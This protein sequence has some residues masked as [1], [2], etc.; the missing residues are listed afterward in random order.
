VL[1][2]YQPG[3]PLYQQNIFSDAPEL[4]YL[5][6]DVLADSSARQ[7][8]GDQNPLL[9]DRTAAVVN[10]LTA[11]RVENWTVGYT[12][13]MVIGVHLGRAD[14]EPLALAD[15][16]LP[17]AA[18][19]W[20][21][22]MQYAN[23]RDGVPP[24]EWQRPENVIELE[25]CQRSGL[26]PNGIC[27][28]KRDLFLDGIE[29]NQPDTFWQAFRINTQTGLLATANTPDALQTDQVFFVPPED[30]LDWWTANRLRLP[31]T[32]Y[33]AIYSS[34]DDVFGVTA[35]T[36][37][38]TYAYIQGEVEIRGN[39]NTDNL[40]YY[41]LAYGKD[42][43]PTQWTNIV[44]QQ[45]V[46]T[47]GEP[48][49]MWDTAG[50]DGL[51]TLEL[52]AVLQNGVRE[53]DTIQVRIDNTPPTIILNTDQPGKIY[54][55][56][57]EQVITVVATVQDN[58]TIARVEFYHNGLRVFTDDEFPFQYDYGITGTGIEFFRADVFDAAGNQSTSEEI[59]VEVRR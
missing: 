49:V 24:S 44:E 55:F 9:L 26:L 58:F 8:L 42:L 21:A 56:P 23:A 36:L 6:N 43:N 19:V 30:A 57:E 59:Q 29:P 11:D 10:G 7:A 33:D 46:F 3:T 51:Y 37:P 41:R 34:P 18:P 50:L 22:I 1:W 52:T 28:V 45:T 27:P 47:P 14:G 13:Q 48:L 5:V 4:G 38:E 54:R 2:E 20:K 31:P 25:V 32:D 16:A 12:P 53:T 40:Q 35:I 15:Y 17:G 39:V